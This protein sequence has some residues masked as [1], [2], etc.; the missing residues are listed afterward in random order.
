M[1][2]LIGILIVILLII[3]STC[4]KQPFV[5]GEDATIYLEANPTAIKLNS[6]STICIS[7]VKAN[8]YPLPDDTKV[9][10]SSDC[11]EIDRE[12]LLKDGYAELILY[13]TESC[14]EEISVTAKSGLA[15]IVPE[16]LIVTI[17]N[18]KDEIAYLYISADPVT[19]PVGGGKSTI[20]V[21]A[22]DADMIPVSDKLIWLETNSGTLSGSTFTTNSNGKISAR[23]KTKEDATV[24]AKHLSLEVSITINVEDP[25]L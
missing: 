8:G 22:V 4:K 17:I 5:P 20:T 25:I 10:I 18:D 1:K 14:I 13:S 23:L 11:G 24:T 12:V 19:L 15:Q 7:G 6:T 9:E 16:I 3:F 2:G 21:L